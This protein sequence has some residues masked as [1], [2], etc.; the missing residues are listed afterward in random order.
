MMF[1]HFEKKKGTEGKGESEK[2][3]SKITDIY[4]RKACASDWHDT[5]KHTHTNTSLICIEKGKE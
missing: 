1:S 3:A 4:K 5:Y 2:K